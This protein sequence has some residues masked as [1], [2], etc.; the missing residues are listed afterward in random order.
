[1]DQYK[2]FEPSV[3]LLDISLPLQDGFEAC[4]QMRAHS[5]M[6]VPRIIAITALSS[7]EDKIKG[8]EVCGMDDWRTKPLSIKSLRTDLIVW[9]KEWDEV[10]Q[11][12]QAPQ[13]AAAPSTQIAVA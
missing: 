9:K 3:V 2:S 4:L 6:H 5:M 13:E 11:S 8:L 12:Q 7:T 10:W 1:M